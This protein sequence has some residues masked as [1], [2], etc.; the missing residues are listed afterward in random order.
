MWNANAGWTQVSP[1]EAAAEYSDSEESISGSD[2][3]SD[4]A[5]VAW[6]GY[7]NHWLP[8]EDPSTSNET[9]MKLTRHTFSAQAMG[10]R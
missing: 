4:D 9:E 5:P 1:E 10:S 8:S 2:S 3:E 6:Q 7:T